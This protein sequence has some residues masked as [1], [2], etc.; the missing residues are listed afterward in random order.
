MTGRTYSEISWNIAINRA[1]L[2]QI[3]A[4]QRAYDRPM[5]DPLVFEFIEM[6]IEEI[7][8]E[9]KEYAGRPAP[10]GSIGST[11]ILF[12]LARPPA[13]RSFQIGFK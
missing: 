5:F 8:E 13:R 12:P 10:I 11:P 3:S 9:I 7:R 1:L 6:E 2:H 4:M